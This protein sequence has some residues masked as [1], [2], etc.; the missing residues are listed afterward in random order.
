MKITE[1]MACLQAI[2]DEHGDLEV[3]TMSR[4]TDSRV[5]H[6]GPVATYV[7]VLQDNERRA[8]FVLGS[9]PKWRRGK[10]VCRI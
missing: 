10:K 7:R 3:D 1:F 8:R 5:M 2:L 6:T 9:D 4:I